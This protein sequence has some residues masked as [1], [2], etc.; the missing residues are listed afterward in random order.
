MDFRVT[1]KQKRKIQHAFTPHDKAG[2]V[3]CSY[4]LKRFQVLEV[5]RNYLTVFSHLIRKLCKHQKEKKE[6]IFATQVLLSLLVGMKHISLVLT[7]TFQAGRLSFLG[8]VL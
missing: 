7:E 8:D 5:K 2:P 1:E 6:L 3:E 4:S